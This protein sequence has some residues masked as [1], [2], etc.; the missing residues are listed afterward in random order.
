MANT[1]LSAVLQIIAFSLI[2]FIAYLIRFRKSQSFFDF[3]GLKSYAGIANVYAVILMIVLATPMLIIAT[4]SDDFRSALLDPSSVTGSIRSL[5]FGSEA[6]IIILLAA[7]FKT[8]L[9]EEILFRGFLAKRLIAITSYKTG[10]LLQALIFGLI[11]TLL[12]LNITKDP[13][14]LSLI[15][16]VPTIGAYVK[17]YLNEKLANGSIIPGWIAHASANIVA[18]SF[19]AFIL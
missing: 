19:I 3:I 10:N 2:P 12:F 16:F 1:L 7:I 14:F 8:G 6:I 5:G 13:L 4:L 18:Y 11:H 17:T 9:S 15:F